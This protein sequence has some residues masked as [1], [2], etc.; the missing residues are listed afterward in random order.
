[1]GEVFRAEIRDA[2]G[3]FQP[4]IPHPFQQFESSEWVTLGAEMG[5]VFGP[6]M[7]DATSAF[8]YTA[9]WQIEYDGYE[10]F[11]N[12]KAVNGKTKLKMC[13]FQALKIRL[14]CSL[15]IESSD[16]MQAWLSLMD[17]A[18]EETNKFQI[19][20]NREAQHRYLTWRAQKVCL[21]SFVYYKAYAVNAMFNLHDGSMCNA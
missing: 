4:R 6:E 3:A 2:T 19:G 15:S 8:E 13:S 17:Q 11:T 12:L 9:N 14:L 10:E 20:L 18:K 21:S 16:G 5:E 1:M 7:R